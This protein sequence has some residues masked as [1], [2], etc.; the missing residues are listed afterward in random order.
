M[1]AGTLLTLHICMKSVPNIIL[2]GHCDHMWKQCL[3]SLPV[4]SNLTA[5]PSNWMSHWHIDFAI[6]FILLL[7]A[8]NPKSQQVLSDIIDS[9]A[10]VSQS[11][12]NCAAQYAA[13]SSLSVKKSSTD[14]I[15]SP[16]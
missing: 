6:T 1:N 11:D 2:N 8:H 15:N 12:C 9:S 16:E 10:P 7:L 4:S 5:L 13:A 3:C 14:S